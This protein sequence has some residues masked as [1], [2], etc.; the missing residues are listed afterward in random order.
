MFRK[1]IRCLAER[2]ERLA[3]RSLFVVYKGG[4]H[5]VSAFSNTTY[6]VAARGQSAGRTPAAL[7]RPRPDDSRTP[8]THPLLAEKGAAAGAAAPCARSSGRAG[9]LLA[10]PW[11]ASD[12]PASPDRP[13]QTQPPITRHVLRLSRRSAAGT[14]PVRSRCRRTAPGIEPCP[15]EE[16]VF[17]KQT[18]PAPNRA[19]PLLPQR[20]TTNPAAPAGPSPA[21]PAG[22]GHAAPWSSRAGRPTRAP[23]QKLRAE[24]RRW[25]TPVFPNEAIRPRAARNRGRQRSLRR[26]GPAGWRGPEAIAGR[27]ESRAILIRPVARIIQPGVRA[28]VVWEGYA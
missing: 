11:H 7:H 26:H 13:P 25:T 8:P 16:S 22:R 20:V 10:K 2:F 9:P 18:H 17:S 23:G 6:V 15:H 24:H 3:R 28:A 14:T 4:Y 19:Q 21:A 1:T 5:P 12:P 27:G